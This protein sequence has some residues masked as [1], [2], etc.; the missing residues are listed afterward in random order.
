MIEP[1]EIISV[2][3]LKPVPANPR[4]HSPANVDKIAHSIRTYG[5]TTPVL[6]DAQNEVI[7]GHGRLLAAQRLALTEVPCIRLAHLTPQLVRAYRIAD[8]RLA[9]DS[10]WDDDLLAAALKELSAQPGF[11]L[12]VTGFNSAEIARIINGDAGLPLPASQTF[13]VIIACSD[14]QTQRAL[15]ERLQSEGL[16][17]RVLT[18]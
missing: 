12:S 18:Y 10:E 9:L 3:D 8:N 2:A 6:I 11:D 7:A 1:I 16:Q 5:W 15:F 14:E 17:C 13:E 4:F